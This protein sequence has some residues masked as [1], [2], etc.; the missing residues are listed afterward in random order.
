MSIAANL[1]LKQQPMSG[2]EIPQQRALGASPSRPI[3]TLNAQ[4]AATTTTGAVA[5]IR[6]LLDTDVRSIFECLHHNKPPPANLQFT[7]VPVGPNGQK[8]SPPSYEF[9]GTH[10]FASYLNLS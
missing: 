6:R 2:E 7:I 10:E 4:T 8:L 9:T 3:C 1:D 5:T